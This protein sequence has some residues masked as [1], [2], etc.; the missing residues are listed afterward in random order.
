[1]NF[2]NK[3]NYTMS[4]KIIVGII[5][6][7]L[8]RSVASADVKYTLTDLNTTAPHLVN[9]LDNVE[10]YAKQHLEREVN[11]FKPHFEF[12]KNFWMPV[13]TRMIINTLND[14]SNDNLSFEFNDVKNA[15]E[16]YINSNSIKRDIPIITNVVNDFIYNYIPSY[17]GVYS[18]VLKYYYDTF[19]SNE[20]KSIINEITTYINLHFEQELAAFELDLKKR[21]NDIIVQNY[22]NNTLHTSVR[23]V[24]GAY[25]YTTVL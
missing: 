17:T 22:C 6:F 25:T 15:I 16:R 12:L 3:I 9:L 10:Q 4:I 1:M 23:F 20:L 14:F 5:T 13:K 18:T 2:Y 24:N 8:I 21:I 11:T 7:F 19:A